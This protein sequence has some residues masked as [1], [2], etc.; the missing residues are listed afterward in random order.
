MKDI[1]NVISKIQKLMAIANDPSA[2]DQE[3]QL[4]TYRAEK[5]MLKYKIDNIDIIQNKKRTED[6]VYQ[7]LL[8]KKYT[9]YLIWTLNVICKH[10]QCLG[11]Y[12]GKVNSKVYLI[13]TGF[14]EDIDIAKTMIIPVMDYMENTL[15]D[16]KH[17]YIGS[18]D[19]RIFKRE[20][21]HGFSDG[22]ENQLKKAFI[23]MKKDEKFDEKFELA[24]VDLHPVLKS[25]QDKFFDIKTCNFTDSC[26]EGYEMGLKDGSNY[27]F[28]DSKKRL[29]GYDQ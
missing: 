1:K 9:G 4:A 22:I 21:C 10:C 15:S 27:Q 12:S 20:W 13:I 29:V 5:L 19:F 16:L 26:W 25:Y 24:V 23:E 18:K 17:C 11:S 6:D 14:K 3:I 28:N 7:Y 8:D 2:S